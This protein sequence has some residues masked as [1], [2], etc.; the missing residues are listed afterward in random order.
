MHPLLEQAP[1][2][3]AEALDRDAGGRGFVVRDPATGGLRASSPLLEPLAAT[4]AERSE[5]YADHEALF[6]ASGE[7]TGALL[8]AFIHRTERGQAQGGLRHWP[9]PTVE[10][11]VCDGLRL[12]RGMGRKCALAGLWWGG[13][14]GLIARQNDAAWRDPAYR[15]RLYT[16]YARFVTSLRGCYITA[17]DAGTTPADMAVIHRHTR[18]ATC[19]PPEV[20]GSGNPSAMTAAGVVS[21][22]AAALQ[23]EG[24][25]GLEGKRI[26]MQGAGNVGSVMIEL[27]LERGVRSIVASEISQE[28]RSL[29]LHRHCGA[30]LE[31]RSAEPGD[32]S[33]LATECDVLA[34]NALGG[35]LNEKT[36]PSLRTKVICGAA[37]NQLARSERDAALIAARGIVYVPDF[38]ANRM[39]IV[40]CSN[41]QTG[42]LEGDPLITRHLDPAWAGSIHRVTRR[43]LDRAREQG[44]SPVVAA[45][46]L[47]DE[48][49]VELH[50]IWGHRAWQIIEGLTREGGW[51][52]R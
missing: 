12:A 52:G 48:A 40:A 43:V 3:L 1:A 37:N 6:F 13:G 41:E 51:I 8:G 17:E 21:A 9:Y 18:F 30:P 5:D 24:L 23:S 36:I 11:F 22:M 7:S 45:C 26:A 38:V 35:I 19:I 50:P 44:V 2:R 49:S 10:A 46:R 32:E 28:Q 4:L 27:L 16:D 29:L 47:A 33:I 34:P 25:G 42:S 15:E 14:K 20:G 39:G 31:V